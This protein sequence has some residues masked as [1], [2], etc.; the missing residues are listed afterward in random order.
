[1][2]A[3]DA[4]SAQLDALAEKLEAQARQDSVVLMD[5]LAGLRDLREQALA[6]ANEE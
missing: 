1:M 6:A 3:A 5:V 2:V 4:T